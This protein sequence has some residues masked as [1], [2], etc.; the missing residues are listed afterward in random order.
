MSGLPLA[1]GSGVRV[2]LRTVLE[3][4]VDDG[5]ANGL[6]LLVG[7]GVV[8]PDAESGCQFGDVVGVAS[9]AGGCGGLARRILKRNKGERRFPNADDRYPYIGFLPRT[10]HP[11]PPLHA[12]IGSWDVEHSAPQRRCHRALDP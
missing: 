3:A 12:I 4:E 8:E 2:H 7:P 9:L 11:R 6:L 1:V 5:S 10:V